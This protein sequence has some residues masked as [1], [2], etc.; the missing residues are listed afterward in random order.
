MNEKIIDKIYEQAKNYRDPVTN[1]IFDKFNK[2][3]VIVV[4]E[5]NVNISLDIDPNK[6]NEYQELIKN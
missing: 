1:K 5:G 4:K 3:I 2:D 6:E